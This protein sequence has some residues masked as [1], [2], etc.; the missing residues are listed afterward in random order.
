MDPQARSRIAAAIAG[1]V[2]LV[3]AVV[4]TY[5]PPEA[6]SWLDSDLV[7]ALLAMAISLEIV[8]AVTLVRRTERSRS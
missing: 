7:R 5:A 8:T 3:A 2:A 1:I 4:T 6:L